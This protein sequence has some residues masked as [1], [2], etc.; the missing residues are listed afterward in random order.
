MRDNFTVKRLKRDFIAVKAVYIG[1]HR[2]E[3]G[4]H[5]GP[6]SVEIRGRSQGADKVV[7]AVINAN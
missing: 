2:G 5:L 7:S 3:R 6:Q 1:N 4:G